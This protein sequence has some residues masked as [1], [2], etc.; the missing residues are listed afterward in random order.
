M[1]NKS[2]VKDWGRVEDIGTPVPRS[3]GG[4]FGV[5]VPNNKPISTPELKALF[6]KDPKAYIERIRSTNK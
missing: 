5:R 6:L 4:G 1:T 2:H 3:P